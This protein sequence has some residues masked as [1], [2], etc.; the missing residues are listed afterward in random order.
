MVSVYVHMCACIHGCVCFHVCMLECVYM[1][2]VCMH[3]WGCVYMV[4]VCMYMHRYVCVCM[5]VCGGELWGE[6][7][8]QW[9]SENRLGLFNTE[10]TSSDR[11]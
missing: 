1:G 11:P 8:R 4:Y 2:C 5:V 7:D 9:P 10:T 6:V 3:V